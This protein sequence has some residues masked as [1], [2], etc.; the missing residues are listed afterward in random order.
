M[1]LSKI[2]CSKSNISRAYKT[3]RNRLSRG[4]GKLKKGL[5]HLH[6]ISITK[7]LTD[8]YTKALSPQ[9]FKNICFK[10]GLINICSPACGGVLKD[11][12]TRVIE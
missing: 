10:L 4:K 8:I 5:I 9:S 12:D 7:Q 3:Y 11:T 2:H 1:T 6:P